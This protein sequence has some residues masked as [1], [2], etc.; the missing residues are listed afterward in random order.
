MNLTESAVAQVTKILADEDD[1]VALRVVLEGGGC[2][3]MMYSF[4]LE[5][6]IAEIAAGDIVISIDGAVVIVDPISYNMH[7]KEA[8]L[9]FEETLQG[10]AFVLK[11]PTSTSCG[12]GQSFT[13]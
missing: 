5:D 9:D 3:G 12:C 10:S 7:L 11:T 8:T 13:I 6:D 4:V 2:S 1:A